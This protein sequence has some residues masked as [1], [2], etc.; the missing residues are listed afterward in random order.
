MNLLRSLTNQLP[1]RLCFAGILLLAC[2]PAG[3]ASP[4]P[5]VGLQANLQSKALADSPEISPFYWLKRLQTQFTPPKN[6]APRST[7][8]TGTR[9]GLRCQAEEPAIAALTP[10]GNYSLTL[11][12]PPTLSLYM[13]Q[14]SA[15]RVAIVLQNESG[16]FYK[17]TMLPIP[18]SASGWV[19][20]QPPASMVV[21]EPGQLYRWSLVVVCGQTPQPDDPL[22]TG[23]IRPMPPASGIH[24]ELQKKTLAEQMQWYGQNG[25]WYDLVQAA[26]SQDRELK[27]RDQSH[28]Q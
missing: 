25:Y 15:T 28:P 19:N 18:D 13:G 9:N 5:W 11:G 2:S 8:G 26:L 3:L 12:Q 24:Q 22:F 7:A 23:W 20:F 21:L 1:Q 10:P 6:D 17:R 27:S 14:A 16:S 4:L